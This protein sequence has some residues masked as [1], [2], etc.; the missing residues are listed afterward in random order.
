VLQGWQNDFPIR[1]AQAPPAVAAGKSS[2][3]TTHV[4]KLHPG[5]NTSGT[6]ATARAAATS[7]AGG[8]Q[9]LSLA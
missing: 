8:H 6:A 5:S 7:A 4:G 9:L 3:A 1:G 2:I